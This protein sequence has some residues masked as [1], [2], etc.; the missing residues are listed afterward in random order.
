MKKIDLFLEMGFSPGY[1]KKVGTN[2]FVAAGVM[3]F[4]IAENILEFNKIRAAMPIVFF[5]IGLWCFGVA[6]LKLKRRRK[7]WQEIGEPELVP[8][9]LRRSAKHFAEFGLVILAFI[10]FKSL[11]LKIR[12]DGYDITAIVVPFLIC[13]YLL[14]ESKKKG[15]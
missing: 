10:V 7:H 1:L 8:R 13:G 2:F 12:P 14:W 4:I 6:E 15:K 3:A 5:A 9:E 11:L